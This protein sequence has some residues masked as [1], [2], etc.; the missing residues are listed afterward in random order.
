MTD[1][2]T[3]QTKPVSEKALRFYTAD[4]APSLEADGIMSPPDIPPRC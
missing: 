4:A 2:A 3:P 1:T